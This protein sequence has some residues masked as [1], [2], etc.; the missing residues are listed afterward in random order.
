MNDPIKIK[1]FISNGGTSVD[2]LLWYYLKIVSAVTATTCVAAE[3]TV[4]LQLSDCRVVLQFTG[5]LNGGT[6]TTAVL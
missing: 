5:L 4:L 3:R 2:L 6:R 1:M